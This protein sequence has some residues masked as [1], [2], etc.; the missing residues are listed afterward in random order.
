[1]ASQTTGIQQLLMAEKSAAVKV[2]EARVR[3]TRRLKQAKEEAQAEVEA[4]RKEREHQFR[5]YEA[6]HMGSRDDIALKI[7]DTTKMR[8]AE[9]HQNVALNKEKVLNRILS[10]VYDIKPELHRNF[11]A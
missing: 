3:K 5:E 10:L 4:Y 9:M 1:M 2:G 7:E 8:I 6:K 11:K